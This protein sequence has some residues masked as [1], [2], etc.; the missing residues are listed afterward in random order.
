MKVIHKRWT[1]TIPKGVTTYK[2]FRDIVSTIPED[3][4]KAMWEKIKP[5]EVK[6]KKRK[7]ASKGE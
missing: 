7:K 1:V 4:V 3:E 2:A 5:K 6:S